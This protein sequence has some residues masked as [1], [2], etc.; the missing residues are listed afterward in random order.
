MN[1]KELRAEAERFNKIAAFC[2]A[3]GETAGATAAY[4]MARALNAEADRKD[5]NDA[6][7]GH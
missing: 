6:A 2:K 3:F 1:K 4:S 7:A 5:R